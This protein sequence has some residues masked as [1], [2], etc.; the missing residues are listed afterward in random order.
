MVSSVEYIEVFA[1]KGI[2]T[3]VDK[4]KS[5]R[6]CFGN[7]AYNRCNGSFESSILCCIAFATCIGMCN[8]RGHHCRRLWHDDRWHQ[9]RPHQL[10]NQ[11]EL[12][13]DHLGD[14]EK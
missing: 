14:R 3:D 6:I 7:F 12:C 1:T 10:W 11:H 5:F 4:E 13:E 9:W 2:V 8:E